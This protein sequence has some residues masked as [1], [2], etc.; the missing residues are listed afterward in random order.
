MKLYEITENYKELQSLAEQDEIPAEQLEDTLSLIES[1]FSDKANAMLCVVE[2]M[3]SDI[4]ALEQQIKRLQ[5][6][7]RAIENKQKS[8]KEYLRTNME[9]TGINK[10]ET[11]FFKVSL[12][13]ATVQCEIV[14]LD[15][16]PDDY[17]EVKTTVSPNKRKILSD[18]KEGVDVP[19]AK[20]KDGTRALRIS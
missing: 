19:G 8:L 13:K 18:L 10:I 6:K 15:L 7:K 5:S 3:N 11:P 1:D 20:I 12:S 9:R 16:L 14:D 4:V 2:N 17:V